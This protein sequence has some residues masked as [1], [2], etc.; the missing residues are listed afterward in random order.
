MASLVVA[1]TD[2]LIDF[3]RGQG[4]GAAATRILIG[5]RRLRLTALTAFE[6]RLGGDFVPRQQE[7]T[8][9]FR[10]RTLELDIAS[11]LLAGEVAIALRASGKPIGLADCLQAGICLRH[12]LPL[13]TRNVRHFGRVAGL[14][15]LDLDALRQG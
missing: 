15:L 7:I 12:G 10:S 6:L 5:Q 14:E 2:L 1:D 13:A 4:A 9:L 3:L 11:A 8:R